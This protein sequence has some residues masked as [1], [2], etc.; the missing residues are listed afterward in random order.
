[1][2]LKASLI[3][4]IICLI[5]V[6]LG[7]GAPVEAETDI[8]LKFN[9]LSAAHAELQN[10]H[11]V[12]LLNYEN[13]KGVREELNTLTNNYR[14]LVRLHNTLQVENTVLETQFQATNDR[15]EEIILSLASGQEGYKEMVESLNEQYQELVDRQALI[16]RQ[17]AL[18]NGGKVR[19]VTDNLTAAEYK[20]FL[21]GW[22][23][24]WE[25]F[26]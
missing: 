13:L 1:M 4:L 22:N 10:R 7:C 21:K 20:A 16:V 2:K 8:T 18:V 24:W 26:N 17:L 6:P 25:S 9:K 5:A 12:V 15:Y 23:V 11:N 3:T 19:V 14:E